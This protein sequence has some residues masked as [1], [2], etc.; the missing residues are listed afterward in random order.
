[1]LINVIIGWII[2]WCIGSYFLRQDRSVFI[3][4]APVASVIAFA[5][6]EVGYQMKWWSVTP[7][8]WGVLSFLP[9]NLGVFPVIP[10]LL[11]YTVRRTSL[12][13]LLLLLIF[14]ICKTLFEFCLVLGGKVNYDHGWNLGWTFVSYLLACSLC[15]GW[16]LIVKGR[17]QGY[18]YS[19]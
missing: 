4:I 17:L 14:T 19:G 3:Q 1:M 10:C 15:Y 2:P 9:Y 16:Y 13:P 6:N 7:T 18:K 5:F 11:I 12:Y 8:G